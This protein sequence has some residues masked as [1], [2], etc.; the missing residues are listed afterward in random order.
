[1]IDIK[2]NDIVEGISC[3]QELSTRTLRSRPAYKIAKLLKEVNNEYQIFNEQRRALIE[4]Y[5]TKD[6]NG[7]LAVDENGNYRIVQEKIGEFN[8]ELQELLDTEINLNC[9]KIDLDDLDGEEFTPTQMMQMSA[10]LSE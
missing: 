3:M 6:E 5:G 9:S 1:M 10:F 7:Q 4:K 8:K 2:L